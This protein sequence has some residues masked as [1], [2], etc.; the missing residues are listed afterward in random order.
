MQKET[1]WSRSFIMICIT[2]FFLFKTFYTQVAALPVFVK[3]KFSNNAT[4]IGLVLIL[5]VAGS[6]LSRFFAGLLMSRLGHK[7]LLLLGTAAVSIGRC[8]ISV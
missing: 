7:R 3:D 4:E 2:N 5:F 8:S 6:V 1:V